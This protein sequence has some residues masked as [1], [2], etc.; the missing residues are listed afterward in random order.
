MPH[1]RLAPPSRSR[2]ALYSQTS[3]QANIE[4]T[5]CV[6]GWTATVRPSTS[7][8]QALKKLMLSRVGLDPKDAIK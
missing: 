4:T 5:I 2:L 6:S 8:T 7:F 3:P 1:A